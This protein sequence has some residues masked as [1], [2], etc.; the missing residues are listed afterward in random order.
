M[1]Q[2]IHCAEG[3]LSF[4]KIRTIELANAVDEL[5]DRCRGLHDER[6]RSSLFVYKFTVDKHGIAPN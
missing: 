5:D 6:R 3:S 2:T 4:H 1:Y